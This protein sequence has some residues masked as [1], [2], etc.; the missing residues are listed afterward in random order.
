LYEKVLQRRPG[1][2]SIFAN[3]LDV[4]LVESSSRLPAVSLQSLA[5]SAWSLSLSLPAVSGVI[6]PSNLEPS[7]HQSFHRFHPLRYSCVLHS[8]IVCPLQVLKRGIAFLIYRPSVSNVWLHPR[9]IRSIESPSHTSSHLSV[10]RLPCHQVLKEGDSL[11]L[12]D[13]CIRP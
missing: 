5:T 11:R 4:L 12:S 13:S 7:I 6:H 8:I 3:S 2:S 9:Q 1:L 10:D